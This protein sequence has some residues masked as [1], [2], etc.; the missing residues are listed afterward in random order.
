MVLRFAAAEARLNTAVFAHLA[1][2][3]AV[4][5]GLPVDVIFEREYLQ[6]FDGIASTGPA[7]TAPSTALSAA[8]TASLLVVAGNTYRVRSIQADGTGISLLLL[9]LQ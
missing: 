6:A 3:Q 2:V 8:T 7:A 9:E 4:L 1:N 5:D